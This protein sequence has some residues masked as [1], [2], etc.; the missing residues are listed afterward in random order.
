MSG[1]APTTGMSASVEQRYHPPQLTGV[2]LTLARSAWLLTIALVVG[3]Q[4]FSIPFAYAQMQ[5]VFP[6]QHACPDTRY[7]AAQVA[8]LNASGISLRFFATWMI[9]NQ[10]LFLLFCVGVATL[11]FWRRSD[12]WMAIF[13]AITLVLFAVYGDNH[14]MGTACALQPH[15]PGLA[16]VTNVLSQ[17]AGFCLPVLFY[18]FP[19]GQ[20]TPRWTRWMTIPWFLAAAVSVGSA[21][22]FFQH[23]SVGNIVEPVLFSTCIAA[24]VYRYLRV[25]NP[26]ERRQTKW[27]VLGIAVG[28]TGF[29][30][31]I[32]WG[33]FNGNYDPTTTRW[34][35]DMFLVMP[36]ID[37]F[38]SAIPISIGIA[39]LRSKLF[40][41]DLLIN[42]V[43]IYGSVVGLLALLYLV[44]VIILQSLAQRLTGQ[45]SSL[46]IVVST[47]AIAAL[48]Q[49]LR[50]NIRNAIDRRF[51][52]RKYDAARTVA[53]FSELVQHEVDLKRLNEGL[54]AVVDKTMRPAHLSLWLRATPRDEATAR[55]APE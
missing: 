25:S 17:L 4:S 24:Q 3:L 13:S 54:L 15:F 50:R 39:I 45:T 26:E 2:P 28:L 8:A 16:Q 9:A 34:P 18:L 47:L 36:V 6:T 20:W 19:S 22:L 46:A 33:A 5:Q 21:N 41:I 31:I 14:Q 27:V 55:E 32:A 10:I 38:L 29:S 23:L 11:I 30:S 48:F 51:Y 1:S 43:L 7:T 52:R 35:L 42:R 49:P 40:D 12:E 53:K 44:S 37:T